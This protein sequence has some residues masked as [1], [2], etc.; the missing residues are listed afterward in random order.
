MYREY[1]ADPRMRINLGIRR[2]LAP[3][4]DNDRRKIE[5]L[6]SILFT[7]P[8]SPIIYYGD[9]IGMGDNVWLGDRDGVRTPMQ[10]SP[11]RNAGFS[12]ARAGAAVPARH[13]RRRLRLPG[14][15]RRGAG[16][17]ALLAAQ[18]DQA[19]HPRA[20]AAP[21]VRPRQHHLSAAGEPARPGV[22][23][24]VPGRRDPGGQQPVGRPRRRCGWT[25]RSTRDTRPSSCWAR[26]RS[27]R[28]T[29]RRTPSPW[30]RTA[31]SG[32]RCARC[33]PRAKRSS[34]PMPEEW[35][36]QEAAL[37]G[38][39]ARP[40]PRRSAPCRASGCCAS[41]GSATRR[42]RCRRSACTTTACCTAERA[43]NI[44]LALLEVR[45]ME[46]GARP[47]PA[48]R[49]L[50]PRGRAGHGAGA[51]RHARHAARRGARVRGHRRAAH[52]AR[53]CWTPS[54]ASGR[55]EGRTGRFPGA[56]DGRGGQ[57]D[58]DA[59]RAGADDGRGA[60]Q[61]LHR[62]RRPA[63]D[64]DLPQAGGG[65]QPGPGGHPL[66]GG[67]GRLPLRPRAGGV[68]GLHASAADEPH[69]VAGVYQFVPN[70]G[71]AWSVAL[72]ALDRFLGAAS[73]SA[74]DPDTRHRARG[75]A[76]DV[77]RL[78]PGH[79]AAGRDH[80]AHAPGAGLGG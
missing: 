16:A 62:L 74:A 61:H 66:P 68:D 5:L 25:C 24:R 8:G 28:W 1:A 30:A 26:P 77:G 36:A 43:P 4:M 54:W 12:R 49:H 45:F 22:P 76:A 2:R 14:G 3:L 11:D 10:W 6:N 65:D 67:A 69:A 79:R 56:R 44:I 15:E 75:A 53:R 46:G 72:K 21:G 9:E 31:S 80:G 42:A 55:I 47:V 20:Q 73:R 35:A 41:A 58:D 39:S 63:G 64:E 34:G 52:R 27:R 32:S 13:Q 71:D 57:V 60:V 38:R 50:S 17:L 40:W 7:M 51:H 59:T 70:G 19:A 29:R 33:A 78:L 48:P 18:L 37:R 23:A